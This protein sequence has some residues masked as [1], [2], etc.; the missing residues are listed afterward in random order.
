MLPYKFVDIPN[1][2]KIQQDLT[3]MIPLLFKETVTSAIVVDHASVKAHCPLLID[4]FEKNDLVWDIARFFMTAPMSELPIHLDGNH[5]NPKFLALN[6]PIIG[7]KNTTMNWWEQ[8]ELIDVEST[9]EYGANICLFDSD[10]KICSHSL[11]LSSPAIVQINIPHNVSN[12][13]DTT[14]VILSVRFNPEPV[15]LWNTQT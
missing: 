2:D 11:E 15:S 10:N 7:C 6:L 5:E 9:K 12:L 1:F 8:I 13:Q 3:A 4:F 14:R